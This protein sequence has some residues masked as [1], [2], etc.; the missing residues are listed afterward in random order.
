MILKELFNALTENLDGRRLAPGEPGR[1]VKGWA[2]DEEAVG[3]LGP[4]EVVVTDRKKLDAKFLAFVTEGD[5]PA[6]VWRTENEPP[7]EAVSHA[8]EFGLGLLAI[9]PNVPLREL[10]SLFA[11]KAEGEGLLRYSHEAA[12]TLIEGAGGESSVAKLADKL[13]GL[14]GRPVVVEDTVG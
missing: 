13:A 2:V 9:S 4:D 7:P 10:F 11:R 14:L 6:V 1:P 12:R 5:A 8:E 3:W